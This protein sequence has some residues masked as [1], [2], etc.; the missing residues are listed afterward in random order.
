MK[1][2][3]MP[4]ALGFLATPAFAQVPPEALGTGMGLVSGLLIAVVVGAVVGWV[5]TLIVK[6]SGSGLGRDILIGIGGSLVT[7]Y[8]FPAI[9]LNIGS[10]QR[11]PA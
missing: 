3:M 6:G 10:C 11:K 4:P 8:L 7:S 1:K 5:S 9:G 2:H